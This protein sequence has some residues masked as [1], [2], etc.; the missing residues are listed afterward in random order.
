MRLRGMVLP[1]CSS[2]IALGIDGAEQ[3][4]RLTVGAQ[5]PAGGCTSG[6]R[7]WDDG[8]SRRG[9]RC[10]ATTSWSAPAWLT[11]T[12]RAA[13]WSPSS[14]RCASARETSVPPRDTGQ[15]TLKRVEIVA[16][17]DRA[18]GRQ[19]VHQIRVAVID[20]VKDVEFVAP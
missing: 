1:T 15:H 20:D 19:R 10:R 8:H 12:I 5:H 4:R 13:A 9:E 14:S 18:V 7:R 3:F 11:Q 17:D 16:R 6:A 2:S